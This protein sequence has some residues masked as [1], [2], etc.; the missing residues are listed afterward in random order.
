MTTELGLIAAG[1]FLVFV[2]VGWLTARWMARRTRGLR[3][4]PLWLI[5]PAAGI[6]G[7]AAYVV[8]EATGEGVAVGAMGAAVGIIIALVLLLAWQRA[9]PRVEGSAGV[10]GLIGVPCSALD[11]MSDDT[12]RDLLSRWL[13]LSS[14]PLTRV[15]IVP[16][17][18]ELRAGGRARRG[19]A[20]RAP[21]RCRGDPGRERR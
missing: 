2:L 17:D 4:G 15:A 12:A 21:G 9:H 16:A 3:P 19:V 8:T 10:Y 5:V 20:P 13:T 1:C 7:V 18:D 14:G 6:L 11:D